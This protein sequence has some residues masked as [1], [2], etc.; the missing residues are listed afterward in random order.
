MINFEVPEFP[1]LNVLNSHCSIAL[2]R[3]DAEILGCLNV[4]PSSINVKKIY[5]FMAFSYTAC[6]MENTTL[7]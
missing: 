3:A 7:P 5:C 6:S 2:Q 4:I 1:Q